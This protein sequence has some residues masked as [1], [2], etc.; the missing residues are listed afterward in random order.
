MPRGVHDP[1]YRVV[2][3]QLVLARQRKGLSQVALAERLGL[4]QQ[5]I[6]RIEQGERR[7]DFIELIDVA[8]AV[9]VSPVDLIAPFIG[10]GRGRVS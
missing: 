5:L 9:G 4:P 1:R 3:E 7:L 2:I 8:E 6:S 10:T